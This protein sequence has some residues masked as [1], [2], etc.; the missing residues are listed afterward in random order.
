MGVPVH[1]G[2]G[3]AGR[4]DVA[5]AVNKGGTNLAFVT[6]I[7]ATL[8]G[9]ILAVGTSVVV[10]RWELRQV[11]RIRMFDELLPEAASKYLSWLE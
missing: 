4:Q 10:K 5:G 11:T 2:S 1:T 8:I 6:T 3:T 7:I 9:G